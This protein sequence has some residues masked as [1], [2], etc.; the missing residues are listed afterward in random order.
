MII[1]FVYFI[2]IAGI[3]FSGLLYTLHNLGEWHLDVSKCFAR[4]SDC[5]LCL[6]GNKWPVKDIAWLV[7]NFTSY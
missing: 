6:A 3:C 7:G 5:G 1:E 4:I 2:C